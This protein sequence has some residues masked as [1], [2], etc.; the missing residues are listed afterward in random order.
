MDDEP[1][2]AERIANEISDK[3]DELV[4]LY[5]KRVE[6]PENVGTTII[7]EQLFQ[8]NIKLEKALEHTEHEDVE[9]DWFRTD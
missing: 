3:I 8:Q 2:E 1:P 5:N 6:S 4:E 9:V 7:Y